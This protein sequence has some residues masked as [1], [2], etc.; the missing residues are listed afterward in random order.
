VYPS[1]FKTVFDFILFFSRNTIVRLLFSEYYLILDGTYLK[2]EQE[3]S[4]NK[5]S[6]S[7]MIKFNFILVQLVEFLKKCLSL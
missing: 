2:K 6:L 5:I 7:L 4:K 1:A 3:E